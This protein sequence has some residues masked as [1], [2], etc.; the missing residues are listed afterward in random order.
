MNKCQEILKS[1]EARLLTEIGFLACGSGN[2]KLAQLIFEG[3]QTG[4]INRS[5]ALIGLA[6]SYIESGVPGE[7]VK[8]LRENY[9]SQENNNAEYRAFFGLS[10]YAH[11]RRHEA[12][13]ILKQVQ[14]NADRDSA[15]G[16]L[17]ETLL[18]TGFV[19]NQVFAGS[20]EQPKR[21]ART[22]V[23]QI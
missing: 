1:D 16:R 3:L 9:H 20:I 13:K 6:M 21:H 10:L 19:N 22:S 2:I 18:K 5:S 17:A 4:I 11:G 14:S 12:E 15:P 23:G 7:A 8:L